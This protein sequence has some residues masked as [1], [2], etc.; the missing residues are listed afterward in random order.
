MARQ[1]QIR[2][3]NTAQHATFTGA[4]GE[5]TVDVDKKTLVVHDGV[6]PGGSPLATQKQLDQSISSVNT[7]LDSG[8]KQKLQLTWGMN[9]IKN[10]GDAPIYPTISGIGRKI[11]NLLGKSGD[12]EDTSKWGGWQSTLALDTTNK[13]FGGNGIKITL[14]NTSGAMNIQKQSIPCI[15][16]SKY[17]MFSA[18]VK[19]GNAATGI[20]IGSSTGNTA[21]VSSATA[22]TRV[23]MKFTPAQ[24]AS[25]T[26]TTSFD[27]SVFGASG[28]YAYV[29]G[30]MIN[31]ISPADYVLSDAELL[32]KY[33]YVESVQF[34]T[35]P[36]FEIRRNNLVRS[37]SAEEGLA[38]YTLG[39]GTPTLSV[40]NGRI[41]IVS[42]GYGEAYQI[43][44]VQQNK[45]YY[46]SANISGAVNI[47]VY[48]AP[49]GSW[50]RTGIGTFNS[51]SNKSVLILIANASAGTGYFD[52]VMLTEGTTAPAGNLIRGGNGENGVYGWIP[53][54]SVGAM[55]NN[56]YFQITDL[57][58][59]ASQNLR[60]EITV[61]ANTTY[62]FR[63]ISKKG[64]A[65]ARFQLTCWTSNN[66][67]TTPQVNPLYI[68][69]DTSDTV[70]TGTITTTSDTAIM[71][72]EIKVGD[73]AAD[74]GTAYFKEITLVEGAAI[75][76][77]Y[78][79]PRYKSC[80]SRKF[81]LEGLF[82]EEDIFSIENGKLKGLRWW[83]HPAPLYGKDIDWQFETDGT[84][85]KRIY[86][87]VNRF[88]DMGLLSNGTYGIGIL[89]KP[90]GKI[91]PFVDTATADT[92]FLYKPSDH[93]FIRV[94]DSD[95]GWGESYT[96]TSDEVKSFMNG[97]VAVWGD[98]GRIVFWLSSV[99]K[100]IPSSA[101]K[102][103]IS[104]TTNTTTT[105]V[106][107][108][109]TSFPNGR[110]VL[111]ISSTGAVRSSGI[112]SSTTATTV[113]TNAAMNVVSGDTLVLADSS[114][115]DTTL[116]TWCKNNLAPGYE[117]YRLHYKL[118]NPEQLTDANYHIHGD[119]W[120]LQKGDNYVV[121]D[122]GIVLGELANPIFDGS[123]WWNIGNTSPGGY[124]AG[125]PKYMVETYNAVYA[126]QQPLDISKY[127]LT[128]GTVNTWVNTQMY[129]KE[130]LI[131][132][133]SKFDPN[134]RYTVDYQILKTLNAMSGTFSLEF[135][136]GVIPS[137][138]SVG[139]V[140]EDKQKRDSAL[141]T[142]VDLSLYE[143]IRS[144]PITARAVPINGGGYYIRLNIPF[145]PKKTLPMATVKIN[146]INA[147][148][149]GGVQIGI[150]QAS[151][152]LFGVYRNFITLV[153]RYDG[154]DTT[155]RNN[156][157][158]NGMNA[159]VDVILDCRGRV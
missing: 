105:Q 122:T 92:G 25:I 80:E 22:F 111:A 9:T 79:T 41:K 120:E 110:I 37:G 144:Y 135:G 55:F 147:L 31:E 50:I 30:V 10:N 70:T 133:N 100:S 98:S 36:Y 157:N 28:Q 72:I 150:T 117:G 6:T 7:K 17:Y 103:T 85:F 51:G 1:V 32:A 118:A 93:L 23:V 5:I 75:P 159:N 119:I 145:M 106:A 142:L 82:S 116:V 62:S 64:T 65:N 90:D 89:V 124:M 27:V 2:K 114:G 24:M 13:V 69:S 96:P 155:I 66:G 35:N 71:V 115:A 74:T 134:A 39:T 47:F 59:G 158:A 112:V 156:I 140:L 94:P 53:S 104:A 153:I 12:C 18:Y 68:V 8:V 58:T 14:T 128:V 78:A 132:N 29:D 20:R 151:T 101:I 107:S 83:D 81:V 88:P 91:L 16:D 34:L 99:D 11:V 33:P 60:Q 126:N 154:G 136:Q 44:P 73:T 40:E 149:S 121:M 54:G 86:S 63:F 26:A 56:G 109:G 45:D 138:E 97:W 61:K 123:A 131:I 46:L 95:S 113:V 15:D 77:E 49:G 146:S 125:V 102:A 57:D 87:G 108:G 148:D 141:D 4:N 21:M 43:V 129:G 137:L 38:A 139:K 127:N 48:T 67:A 152:V 52:S 3:G 130:R 84:G 76:T 42:N 19:N 143:E